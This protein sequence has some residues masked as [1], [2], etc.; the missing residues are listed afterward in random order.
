MCACKMSVEND[1]FTQFYAHVKAETKKGVCTSLY[2]GPVCS[3]KKYVLLKRD[4]LV[5]MKVLLMKQYKML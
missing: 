1:L 4:I 3:S 5:Y 2:D